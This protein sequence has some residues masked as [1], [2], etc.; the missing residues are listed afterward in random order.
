VQSD[1]KPNF[2]VLVLSLGREPNNS[3][4]I[5]SHERLFLRL[6]TEMRRNH[7]NVNKE[8]ALQQFQQ[9]SRILDW[10]C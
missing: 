3:A 4:F 10:G 2:S 9:Q 7:N 6:K 8:I 5:T 1:E